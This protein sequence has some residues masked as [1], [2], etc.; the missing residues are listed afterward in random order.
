MK[1]SPIEIEENQSLTERLTSNPWVVLGIRLSVPVSL[2]VFLI[3]AFDMVVSRGFDSEEWT[4]NLEMHRETMQWMINHPEGVAF[5][6]VEIVVIMFV[7]SAL[8][9]MSKQV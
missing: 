2:T 3:A 6:V 4:T 9:R 1:K 5:I 8:V 7:I